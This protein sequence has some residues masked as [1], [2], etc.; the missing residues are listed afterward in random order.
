MAG[1]DACDDTRMTSLFDTLTPAEIADAP[2]GFLAFER[3]TLASDERNRIDAEVIAAGGEIAQRMGW[4]GG[5]RPGRLF[6]RRQL[7]SYYLV[8]LEALGDS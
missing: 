8:P 5:L 6:P 7:I 3:E 2:L 1:P 4:S